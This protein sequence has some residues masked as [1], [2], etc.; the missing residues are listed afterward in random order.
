MNYADIPVNERIKYAAEYTLILKD[1]PLNTPDNI[2]SELATTFFL[3][4]EEAS[5]AYLQSRA[6]FPQEYKEAGKAKTWHYITIITAGLIIGTFYLLMASD[7]GFGFLLIMAL[8]F[9]VGVLAIINLILNNV[10]A[11]FQL[12]YPLV[13][14]LSKNIIIQCLTWT[15]ICCVGLW[16]QYLFGNIV[17][18]EDVAVKPLV[19]TA[20]VEWE[21]TG[22]KSSE[23]YYKF[24]ATGYAKS[25]RFYKS[26]YVF[27]DTLPDFKEY[28]PG[29]T[30]HVQILKED[31]EDLNEESFFSKN[32]RIFGMEIN[33]NS[34]VDY[35]KRRERII[36]SREEWLVYVTFA[37]VA[38]VF[39]ALAYINYKR[40]Q[41]YP[42]K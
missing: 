22:G 34:I 31:I 26:D 19:L 24:S 6:K 42:D 10:L 17:K 39:L 11:N 29:D 27:A 12:R 41:I 25:F 5:V 9:F 7:R 14:S 21:K 4:K 3:T 38:N 20:R 32:N 16:A 37:F 23:Y 13:K 35:K 18:Q 8:L 40:K 1:D 36:E 30:V 28:A 33:G 2:I 15:F